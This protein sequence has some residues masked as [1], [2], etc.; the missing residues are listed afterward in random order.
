MSN[1]NHIYKVIKVKK[2]LDLDEFPK[3][4]LLDKA[5]FHP[6]EYSKI[7]CENLN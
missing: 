6:K 4:F 7:F 5:V 3:E 2:A 1:E